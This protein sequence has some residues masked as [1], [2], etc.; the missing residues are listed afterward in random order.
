MREIMNCNMHI[1]CSCVYMRLIAIEQFRKN[2]IV[3][4]SIRKIAGVTIMR[5]PSDSGG[6]PE[7]TM[8]EH[9]HDDTVDI[10]LRGTKISS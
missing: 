6:H 5:E 9:D 7:V 4:A 3:W 8:S 2:F 1:H 10:P